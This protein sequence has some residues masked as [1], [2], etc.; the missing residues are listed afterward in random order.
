MGEISESKSLIP[1]KLTL[2]MPHTL[3]YVNK[4]RGCSFYI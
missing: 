3:I 2:Y 1:S 4:Q